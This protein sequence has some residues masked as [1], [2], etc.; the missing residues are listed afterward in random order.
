ML[1]L[2]VDAAVLLELGERVAVLGIVRLETHGLPRVVE[3]EHTVADPR[4]RDRAEVVPLRVALRGR[5]AR[6]RV[7]GLLIAPVVD[8]I[9]RGLDARR[10]R[11][12]VF[13][14][15]APLG[16]IPRRERVAVPAAE[17]GAA[18]AVGTAVG[19]GAGLAIGLLLGAVGVLDLVVGLVDLV[20][21]PR[22]R[23]VAGVH[24]GVVFFRELTVGLLDL[25]VGGVGRHAE[26]FVGVGD[27][28]TPP[29]SCCSSARP[30][31]VQMPA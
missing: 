19:A 29:F 8:I 14:L 5:D 30:Y 17:R 4:V 15:R 23:L 26:Y 21:L 7:D 1:A 24:V 10:R 18:V 28:V 27:H 2:P 6:E 13:L 3:R 16:V 25:L 12:R 22:G 20:H 11:T 9:S 31:C